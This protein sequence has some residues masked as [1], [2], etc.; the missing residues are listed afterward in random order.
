MMRRIITE[1][2]YPSI[3]VR[4]HDWL[5]YYDGEEEGYTGYGR[6]EAEAIAS[7]KERD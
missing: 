2:I 5:A 7:L 1:Y 3:P 4:D 6:T